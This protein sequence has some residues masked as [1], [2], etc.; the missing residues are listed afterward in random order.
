MGLKAKSVPGC[1]GVIV[2]DVVVA[3]STQFL[4]LCRDCQLV[5]TT[6][7]GE[8]DVYV[9]YTAEVKRKNRTGLKVMNYNDFLTALMK[10]SFKV[11]PDSHSV[12]DSFQRLLMENILPLASRRYVV[13]ATVFSGGA[14]GLR[15]SARCFAGA[16]MSSDHLLLNSSMF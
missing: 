11:Y 6:S 13:P 16:A 1:S 3:Q 7:L 12:D 2:G 14:V 5:G 8:A 15:S 9:A 4:K 10:L